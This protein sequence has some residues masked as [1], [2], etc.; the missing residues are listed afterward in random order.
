MAFDEHLAFRIR[1]VLKS[2]SVFFSE[3]KM[4]GGLCF[5]VDDK[6]CVGITGNKL[7]ARVGETAY[8]SC[9]QKKG[10]HEMTFTG[11]PLKG[12]VYV[13]PNAIDMDE[14]LETWIQY[15]LDF[16]PFANKNK[17]TKPNKT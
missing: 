10:C 11:K 6:M 3:K 9:L 1:G 8:N 2:K 15:C 5:M 16:N 7:M 12:F 17:K 4:M 14:D 13:D